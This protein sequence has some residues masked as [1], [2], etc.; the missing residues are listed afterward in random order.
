MMMPTVRDT[1][2]TSMSSN[3]IEKQW[4]RTITTRLY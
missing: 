2:F 1:A 4:K 3:G